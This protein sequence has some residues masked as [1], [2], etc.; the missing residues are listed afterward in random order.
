MPAR[1]RKEISLLSG[2]K[3]RAMTY[4]FDI[5]TASFISSNQFSLI[6]YHLEVI[7]LPDLL[8]AYGLSCVHTASNTIVSITIDDSLQSFLLTSMSMK[9]STCNH[10]L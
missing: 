3:V 8:L 7:F 10:L 5:P 2:T 4:V 6:S 1:Y 9:I